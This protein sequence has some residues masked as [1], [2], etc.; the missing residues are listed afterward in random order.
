MSLRRLAGL[1]LVCVAALG[2][3]AGPSSEA[4][5]TTGD[6]LTTYG[7]LF[8]TLEGADLDRWYAVRSSLKSGLD[9]ICGDTICSGDY[10]NLTTVSLECSSTAAQRKMKDCT[11][12]LGG[13]I[14]HVDAAAGT[15]VTD[16]RVFTCKV[17]VAGTAPTFLRA[18]EA[19]GAD[20][21]HA[22]L[23]GTAKSFY[24]ALVDCFE[25]VTGQARPATSH[26]PAY[27]DLGDWLWETAN[28]SSWTEI[29]RTLGR[30]FDQICGDTFCE[31]QYPDISALRFVCS[32]KTEDQHVSHCGWSFAEAEASVGDRGAIETN[33][34]TRR[35]DVTIDAPADALVQ[36][37]SVP[38]PLYA[39]LP[40]GTASIYDALVGCL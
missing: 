37:L 30:D 13:S 10:S 40:G 18:L 9:R 22:P 28:G 25:G 23:P 39:P 2:A 35:C 27:R 19:G 11:W 15:I 20:A 7:D 14:D 29:T 6:A 26:A 31:G 8:V 5:E 4:A 12:V 34:A 36:A 16:A 33:V 24:D 21:L 1:S 38:E 32:M 3:C 17:P